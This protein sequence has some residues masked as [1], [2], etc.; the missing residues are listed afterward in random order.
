M[1]LSL[2][3]PDLCSMVFGASWR[4]AGVFIRILSPWLMTSF[5]VSPVSQLP[6]ILKIQKSSFAFSFVENLF[7]LG[8]LV[9][10]HFLYGKSNPSLMLMSFV[11]SIVLLGY[12]TWLYMKVVKYDKSRQ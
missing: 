12:G 3:A 11:S 2:F 1:V 4:N 9:L 6:L 10:G 8:S 5:I 7:I